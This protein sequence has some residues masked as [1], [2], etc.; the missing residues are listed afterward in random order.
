MECAFCQCDPEVAIL[1]WRPDGSEQVT[2]C[3]VCAERQGVWCAVHRKAL[4]G[5]NGGAGKGTVCLDCVERDLL[6]LCHRADYFRQCLFRNLPPRESRRLAEW[7][8]D[9]QPVWRLDSSAIVLRGIILEA[10]RRRIAPDRIVAEVMRTRTV[11]S[12]LPL[13]Y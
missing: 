3:S 2:A 9:M 4:S 5:M 12:I 8:R 13:A 11:G 1:V 6:R 10:H 7:V